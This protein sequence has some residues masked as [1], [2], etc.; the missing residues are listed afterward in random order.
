MLFEKNVKPETKVIAQIFSKT[1]ATY[2]YYWFVS[3]L[4]IV[5]KEQ[6]R[7]ISFWEIIVGMVAE[8]WYPIHYFRLNFGKSDSFYNQIIE[9]QKILNIPINAKKSDIK[10]SIL[11][12]LNTPRIKSILN[13][14]K[15]NVPYRFLS[16]WIKY[17]TD[18]QV[19]LQSQTFTNNCLYAINGES[20]D[21]NPQWEQ[22]L[23]DNY[24][25]LRDYTFWNLTDFI[26]KRNPNVP[27]VPSKLVKPISRE[28]LTKHRNFWNTYIDLKGSIQCIY[29]GKELYKKEY[30]LD[31]F[32]PWSYFTNDSI[33]NIIPAEHIANIL[34]SD[35]LPMLE[36]YLK[37]FA[38]TQ[39][40]AL[41]YIYT[42]N[43]NNIILEDYLTIHDSISELIQLSE[44]D[45]KNVFQKTFTPMVQI[46]ENM[47]FRYWQNKL[48]L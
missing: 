19:T 1:V 13:V 5:V 23:N 46:A 6:R 18:A 15:L 12:N 32:I 25:I 3:I 37:P 16:P 28:S 31:H 8:A 29:T 36:K 38:K 40:E 48:I 17:T 14:F 42:K 27:D 26:Q 10:K 11:T 35:N 22:F 33:W 34:K 41:K 2:K 24:L 47:G 39:H 4:D 20:I 43:P 44:N 30:D 21:I 7:K 45:F 9:I